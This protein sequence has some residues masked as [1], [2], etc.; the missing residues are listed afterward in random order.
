M[1]IYLISF[2]I[3]G[4]GIG[5][6]FLFNYAHNSGMREC[7]NQTLKVTHDKQNKI[8]SVGNTSFNHQLL[9]RGLRNKSAVW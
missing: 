5:T 6:F 7:Q 9:T 8:N 3:L 1:R 2:L 4:A